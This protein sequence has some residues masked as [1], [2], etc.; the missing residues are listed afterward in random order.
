MNSYCRLIHVIEKVLS[1]SLKLE[2]IYGIIIKRSRWRNFSS[3]IHHK[4]TYIISL[5]I[6][7][8]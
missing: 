4:S 1:I 8:P 6:L 2:I 5:L 7:F 3:Y